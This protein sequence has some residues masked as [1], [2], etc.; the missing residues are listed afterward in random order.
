MKLRRLK[1]PLKESLPLWS[2]SVEPFK[3]SYVVAC[4][5]MNVLQ[6]NNA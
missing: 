5:A 2:E 6:L 1:K 4:K 3:P